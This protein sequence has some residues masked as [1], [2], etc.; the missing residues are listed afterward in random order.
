MS[1]VDELVNTY[2][3]NGVLFDQI[4]HNVISLP[5]EILKN[6]YIQKDGD[7]PVINWVTSKTLCLTEYH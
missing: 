2:N 6:N 1:K 3:P 5:K 7:Y 4:G